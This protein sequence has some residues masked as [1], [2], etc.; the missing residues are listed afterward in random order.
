MAAA[1]LAL[2]SLSNYS[3]TNQPKNSTAKMKLSW[4]PYDLQLNHTFTISGF[5]RKTTPVVLT[6]IEYDG[7]EG[8]GEAS[9]PPYLGETQSSVIE[10]LKKV[11][12][13][14]YSDPAHMEEIMAYVD[15]IA[16]NN[17][18]AKAAVDIALHDLAGKMI[19]A[20]WHRMYGLDKHDVPDTTFTIGIDS[21]EVVREK[22]GEALGR[23]HILKVKVGGPDDKR[24][25]EA[26]RSVTDLPLAVDANQGWKERRQ[27]LDMIFWLKEK[28]VVMVEQ[29]MP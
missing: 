26:I 11:D 12:L 28:G 17:T 21:D 27:A 4:T 29:P 19:G 18:A 16:I 5:S 14:A 20:P 15:G 22:T 9:L 2:P 25:I 10:Y 24:M 8:Y 23:F 7:L 3:S 1:A 6:R 13:S